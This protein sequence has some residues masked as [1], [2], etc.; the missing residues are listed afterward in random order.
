MAL[1]KLRKASDEFGIF[2]LKTYRR[3]YYVPLFVFPLQRN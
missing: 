2:F 1:E 3:R